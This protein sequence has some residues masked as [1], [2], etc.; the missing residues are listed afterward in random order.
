MR[1][2]Y[3]DTV[4]GRLIKRLFRRAVQ[5]IRH[6][7]YQRLLYYAFDS[8]LFYHSLKFGANDPPTN[9][10]GR[11]VRLQLYTSRNAVLRCMETISPDNGTVIIQE[12]KVLPTYTAR[13]SLQQDVAFY[14]AHD[15]QKHRGRWFLQRR[16]ITG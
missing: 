5:A 14:R 13:K 1:R 12:E 2:L 4:S 3:D 10:H 8:N 16:N 9:V 7:Q 6:L 11:H 15:E